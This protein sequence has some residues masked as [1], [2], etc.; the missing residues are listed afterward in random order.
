MGELD[1]RTPE[2]TR[3]AQSEATKPFPQ[4]RQAKRDLLLNR[5]KEIGPILQA[6]GGKSEELATLAPEAVEALR[7]AG[8]FRLK[9]PT[10]LGGAEPDPVTEWVLGGTVVEGT[11]SENGGRPLH[12][13]LFCR[14][15]DS[16]VSSIRGTSQ[17][18]PYRFSQRAVPCGK[19]VVIEMLVLERLAYYDFTSAW[20]TMVGATGVGMLDAAIEAPSRVAMRKAA[21]TE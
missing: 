15:R 20:C 8:M 18:H 6:S 5:V 9:L 16:I 17:R 3:Q 1:L 21:C 13:A 19:R 14:R 4:E 10:V 2:A 11:E 12:W 7:S